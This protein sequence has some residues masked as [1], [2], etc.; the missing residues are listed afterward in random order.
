MRLRLRCRLRL[1]TAAA[2][3]GLCSVVAAAEPTPSVSDPNRHALTN[4]AAARRIVNLADTRRIDF[5]IIGDSNVRNAQISG[6]EDGMTRAL[7]ARFG[8]YAT[9]V[10]P[11]AGINSWGAGVTSESAFAFAPF[12]TEVT[13][14]RNPPATIMTRFALPGPWFPNS[15]G[16]LDERTA[17]PFTYNGGL[18][19]ATDHPIDIT[20]AL[21]FHFTHYRW[22][23]PTFGRVVY[24]A[25]GPAY[26]NFASATF[27]TAAAT[28][29]LADESFDVPA[30]PRDASGLM[31]A[32]SDVAG[33]RFTQGPFFGLWQRVEAPGRGAGVAYSPLLYQGGRSARA[34]C[35]EL[36]AIGPQSPALREWLR[37]VTRLQN[38]DPVLVIHLMHGGN[39]AGDVNPSGGPIGGLRSDSP[40]GHADNYRGIINNLRAAWAGLGHNP[41]N[42]LFI[43][44]PYHPRGDRLEVQ[45]QYEQQWVLLAQSDPNIIAI[46]G[47]QMSTEQEFINLG[48]MQSA[49]DFAHLSVAGYRGWCA[50]AV[51]VLQRAACPADL[52]HDRIVTIEDVFEYLRAYFGQQ[53]DADFNGDGV[54]TLED[55]LT[56]LAA[57]FEGC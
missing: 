14:Q 54:M 15:Y 8:L 16:Y 41:D 27:R 21:R 20:R 52:T 56:F 17:L 43:L 18:A 22:R 32:P 39:D 53:P 36:N 29:G 42:L 19:L 49:T 6:H 26:T 10:N 3:A 40:E 2:A 7:A 57:W 50:A 47:T 46:R 38:A 28:P 33:A 37:Q 11:F 44:G 5:A 30:G 35:L 55:L 45:K 24:T 9:R 48:W 4:A 25:R 34:A 12:A 23:T 13:T 51:E 1:L 31:F